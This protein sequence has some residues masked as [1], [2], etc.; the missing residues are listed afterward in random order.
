V[1]MGPTSRTV[2]F[3]HIFPD[4]RKLLLDYLDRSTVN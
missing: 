4:H 3:K 2:R 1:D